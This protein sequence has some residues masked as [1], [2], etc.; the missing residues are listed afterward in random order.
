M[1]GQ[2]TTSA[3]SIG[4]GDGGDATPSLASRTNTAFNANT[5]THPVAVKPRSVAKGGGVWAHTL[6]LTGE[7]TRR[8]AHALEVEIE[9]L[10]AKGVT[11]ITLDLRQLTYIDSVGVAVISFRCG[12][13]QRQGY[14]FSLVPGPRFVQRAFEQAGIVDLLPFEDDS[15]EARRLSA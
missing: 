14:G 13:C 6:V 11:A 7:L 12:L 4:R 15:I 2:L 5:R 8:S 3:V 9:E 1:E 10:C